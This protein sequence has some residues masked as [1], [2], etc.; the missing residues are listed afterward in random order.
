[1]LKKIVPKVKDKEWFFD[2]ELLLLAENLGYRIKEI[3]VDW[4]EK[5]TISKVGIIQTIF[6]YVIKL[7]KLKKRLEYE[8][9]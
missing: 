4:R 9:Y 6:D 3:P 5:R 8:V 2:T 7:L 1:V